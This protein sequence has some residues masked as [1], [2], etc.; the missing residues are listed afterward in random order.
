MVREGRVL[1][2]Q[3]IGFADYANP[4][5]KKQNGVAA[6]INAGKLSG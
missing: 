3:D 1:K 5:F 4:V 2:L 6:T